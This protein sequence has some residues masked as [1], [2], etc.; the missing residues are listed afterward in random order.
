MKANKT[1]GMSIMIGVASSILILLA[2]T[3]QF[4]I[5]LGGD[6][7]IG[8]GEIFTTLSAALGGPIAV[9]VTLLVAYGGNIILNIDLFTDIQ[10]VYITLADA[11]AHLFA[12]LVVVLCY[13]KLLYPRVRK[14]GAFLPGW[15]L[16]VGAYYYLALLPLAV[17]LQS[18]VNP[19]FTSTYPSFAMDFFP[20]FLGTATITTLIWIALPARYRR[21]RWIEPKQEIQDK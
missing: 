13:Y 8:V 14:T 18:L 12:M 2:S 15:F 6:T 4:V 1:V 9:I 3:A 11:A 16:T 19:G 7:F 5:P 20:E 17:A 21:P 10:T